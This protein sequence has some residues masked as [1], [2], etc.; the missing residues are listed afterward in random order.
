MMRLGVVVKRSL[1]AGRRV[2]DLQQDSRDEKTA[3]TTVKRF[4]PCSRV[5]VCRGSVF[6]LSKEFRF[7]STFSLC[8]RAGLLVVKFRTQISVSFSS[9]A[10]AIPENLNFQVSSLKFEL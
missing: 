2:H 7:F 3:L 6:L 10:M 9:N 5:V 8:I 1:V 4:E